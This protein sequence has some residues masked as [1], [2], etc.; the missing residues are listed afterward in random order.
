MKTIKDKNILSIPGGWAD[1]TMTFAWPY[2]DL[3]MTLL[4]PY[5]DLTL[6][7]LWPWHFFYIY[8]F[9]I[10]LSIPGGWADLTMTFAWPYYDL[11]MTLLWPYYDLTMTLAWPWHFFYIYKFYI[12][13]LF[14]KTI[15]DKNIL[16][17]P[18]GWADL[19]MTFAWPYYDLTM[20]LIFYKY[21]YKNIKK[22]F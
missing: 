11:T 10:I 3:T 6:T 15:K 9:Y 20:I 4:W 19:T 18:G 17:I 14:L 16:S 2:Y 7:L 8:K 21:I 12:I 1:L 5:Y 22:R 13:N